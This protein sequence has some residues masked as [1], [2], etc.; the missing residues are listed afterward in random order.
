LKRGRREKE[1]KNERVHLPG[2]SAKNGVAAL[3][4]GRKTKTG[5]KEKS[6]RRERRGGKSET[7]KWNLKCNHRPDD[8]VKRGDR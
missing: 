8:L 1:Q 7:K 4:R 6:K 2:Q 3:V 5:K